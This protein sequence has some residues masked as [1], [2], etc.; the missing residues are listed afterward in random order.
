MVYAIHN[1]SDRDVL[2]AGCT[3]LAMAAERVLAQCENLVLQ[4]GDAAYASESS[5]IR[6]G[7]LGKHLRHTLDH[8]AAALGAGGDGD[9]PI[10]YDD[11]QRNVPMETS[12][13]A[14]VAALSR[15][16]QQLADASGD[17]LNKVVRVRVLL[18]GEGR[19]VEL[20]S[21][22]GRELAFATHHALHHQ[23]MMKAIAAEF[24]VHLD[25]S[26]GTSP[27]TLR[28]NTTDRRA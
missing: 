17:G 15:L 25:E 5:T 19:E 27:S 14:A 16:R 9:H 6:G 11:R 2:N 12:R 23:A 21:T 24:G 7:S 26:F 4:V 22:L 28:S 10:C 13:S 1:T 18:D 3:A 8:F 20:Q